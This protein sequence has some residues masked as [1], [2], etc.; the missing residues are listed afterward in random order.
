MSGM[1]CF[2]S[3]EGQREV[4][5]ARI[6][7][8]SRLG[9]E[10]K[11]LAATLWRTLRDDLRAGPHVGADMWFRVWAGIGDVQVRIECDDPL[12]GLIFAWN[13]LTEA[14]PECGP[15]VTPHEDAALT[16]LSEQQLREYVKADAAF[17]E[18]RA[19]CTPACKTWPPCEVGRPLLDH[20]Q[21]ARAALIDKWGKPHPEDEKAF[22]GFEDEE[23]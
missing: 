11:D 8:A 21:D 23:T 14:F 18:H 2:C 3:E 15:L 17:A 10:A 22:Y 5:A 12:D 1:I 9:V 6:K 20:R 16:E 19:G 7:A 13:T 4:E